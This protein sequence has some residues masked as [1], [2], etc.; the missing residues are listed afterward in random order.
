M[1][2]PTSGSCVVP[3]LPVRTSD[4]PMEPDQYRYIATH[5]W[6]MGTFMGP[7]PA[8]PVH[9]HLSEHLL[10]QWMPAVQDADWLLDRELTGRVTWLAGSGEAADDAGFDLREAW[11]TG[12]F[13][14]KY[15]DFYAELHDSAPHRRAGSWATPTPEFLALLPRDPAEL[16]ARLLADA[17]QGRTYTGPFRSAVDALRT[18]SVPADLRAPL[19]AALL[20]LPAVTLVDEVKDLDGNL[21]LALVHDTGPTRTELLVD[22]VDG[23]YAGERDTLRRD[24]SCG[25]VEGTVIAETSVRTAVVPAIGALPVF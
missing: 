24:S 19:Y 10:Q 18:C 25:L 6:W 15:G 16:L 8:E 20:E 23:Q 21:C 5:A 11:P 1:N 9:V 17:P 4:E 2:L 13:R 7:D 14:A 22:P 3:D 12:R